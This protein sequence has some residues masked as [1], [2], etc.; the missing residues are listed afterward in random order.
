MNVRYF[1]KERLAFIQQF[2]ATTSEAYVE[3][4]RKIKAGE[5]PFIPEYSEDDEPPFLDE[6]LEAHE[7]LQVLGGTCVSMLAAT[8][9]L[10]FKAWERQS[11]VPVDSSLKPAFKDGWLHGYM[12]YF[13]RHTPVR[14]KDAPS[15]LALLEE[16]VLARNRIQHP[17]SITVIGSHY[18][19]D[20]LRKLPRPFFIDEHDL[21]LLSDAEELERGWLVS[22]AIYVS[23]EKLLAA[24]AEV[25][26]FAGWLE[27]VEIETDV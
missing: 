21:A 9:H 19:D 23:S 7:S 17:D 18:S 12:A 22:P 8:L 13:E 6:Y 11:G 3:R 16:L 25:E 15:N 5:E 10:Y 26:C 24:I 27:T 2:Y 1:L 20:D 4:M 14:F